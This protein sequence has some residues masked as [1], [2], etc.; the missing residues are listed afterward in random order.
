MT[1]FHLSACGIFSPFKTPSHIIQ[2]NTSNKIN[3]WSSDQ[4][5][6]VY[7]RQFAIQQFYLGLIEKL[8][9]WIAWEFLVRGKQKKPADD[10]DMVVMFSVKVWERYLPI[11]I[12]F[13]FL[14]IFF[15]TM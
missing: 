10:L 5:L 1:D 6:I 14:L 9:V 2:A 12:F 11:F 3:K 8:S 13:S 15:S 7:D 4:G